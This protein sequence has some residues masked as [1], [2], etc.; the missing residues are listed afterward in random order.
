M[1]YFKN[2]QSHTL[3]WG[4]LTLCLQLHKVGG[5]NSDKGEVVKEECHT[6]I[7]DNTFKAELN[8]FNIILTQKETSSANCS[9]Y[10]G[11]LKFGR[12]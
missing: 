3:Y 1:C 9:K 12:E 6:S 7:I 11:Q 2:P 4:A 10:F 8:L 5:S